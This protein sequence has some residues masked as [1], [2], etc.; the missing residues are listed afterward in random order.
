MIIIAGHLTVD[1]ADRDRY[2]AAHQD[3]VQRSRAAAG[4]LH[5]AITADGVDPTR[6]ELVEVW[7]DAVALEAWRAVA[8]GPDTGIEVHDSGVAR[9]DAVDGGPL[10]PGAEPPAGPLH[11]AVVG[12][13]LAVGDL[14]RARAFYEGQLGLTGER[15]P[16][17]WLLR[18]GHGTVAYLLEG[19]TDAGSASWPVASFRV[20]DVHA[21]V[22]EL[23]A[24]EV[25]F[26]GPGDLPFTLDDDGVSTDDDGIA[27][28]WMRDPDG[29]I[30]TVFELTTG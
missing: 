14:D 3:L 18:A 12:P 24:A 10:F 5:V 27:V 21:T 25:P 29:S 2:V 23:R 6:V 19:I 20:D 1:E 13:V 16:G 26:L 17:G 7:T 15:A 30:V 28:A 11:A 22:R 8:D 4:C 9:Y